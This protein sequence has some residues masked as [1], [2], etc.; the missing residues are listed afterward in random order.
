MKEELIAYIETLT[1][2]QIEKIVSQIPRLTELLE[3]SFQSYPL[4]S[5]E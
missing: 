2:A 1:P 4:G 5:L 3:K